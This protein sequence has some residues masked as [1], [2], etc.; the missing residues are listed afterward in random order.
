V[1]CDILE[2]RTPIETNMSENVVERMCRISE[3]LTHR[4]LAV[5]EAA[6]LRRRTKQTPNTACVKGKD[7]L[8]SSVCS[9][10]VTRYYFFE[11]YPRGI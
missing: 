7:Q 10:E 4:Y 8:R 6:R 9:W 2:H 5:C 11:C 3:D 1:A